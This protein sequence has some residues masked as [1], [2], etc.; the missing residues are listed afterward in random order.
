VIYKGILG[1][2]F[3]AARS[4]PELNLTQS[5]PVAFYL[6]RTQHSCVERYK[7]LGKGVVLSL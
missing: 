4:A 1:E 3:L 6:L 5:F 7:F 2:N